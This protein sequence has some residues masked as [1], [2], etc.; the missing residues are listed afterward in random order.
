[1]YHYRTIDDLINSGYAFFKQI[2]G[3]KVIY[4]N[5]FTGMRLLYDFGYG[6]Y[7]ILD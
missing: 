5:K 2:T 7:K 6:S 3:N 1:M 4:E